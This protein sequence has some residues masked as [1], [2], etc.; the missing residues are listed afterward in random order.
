[1][2][3]ISHLGLVLANT[4]LADTH[5]TAADLR[6]SFLVKVKTDLEDLACL[7]PSTITLST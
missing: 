5:M 2:P 4:E 6:A 7:S 3:E 1:M